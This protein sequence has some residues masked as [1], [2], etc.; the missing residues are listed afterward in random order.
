MFRGYAQ[1]ILLNTRSAL[2]NTG[3]IMEITIK[4][5]E[6]TVP[7]TVNQWGHVGGLKKYKG[8]KVMIVVLEE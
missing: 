4:K 1:R 3:D 8:R 5:V 6:L 7:K 2:Q